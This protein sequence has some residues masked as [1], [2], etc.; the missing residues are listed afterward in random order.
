VIGG[1]RASV[2]GEPLDAAGARRY[3]ELLTG[4]GTPTFALPGPGDLQGG[5]P[6]AFAAAFA[7]AAAPVGTG[8]APDGTTVDPALAPPP[9]PGGSPTRFTFDVSGSAGRVR[10]LAIDNAAGRL[11]GG[12][13][14]PQATWIAR[15]L[16]DARARGVPVVAVGSASL[17]PDSRVAPAA[18]AAYEVA[19]LAGRASAYVAT[20]GG[21]DPAD[22]RFGGETARTVARDPGSGAGLP[23]L[24]TSSLGYGPTYAPIVEENGSLN[25][26]EYA[27]ETT[28]ALLT[29]DVDV[30]RRD[31]ATNVA[32]VA[33]RIELLLGPLLFG[34]EPRVTMGAATTIGANGKDPAQDRRL[35]PAP[36]GGTRLVAGGRVSVLPWSSCVIWLATCASTVPDAVRFS[37]SDESVGRFVG[38]AN[39]EASGGP[40]ILTDDAG[41]PVD[42]PHLGVFCPVGLG[43]TT[44]T[45]RAMGREVRRQITVVPPGTPGAAENRPESAKVPAGTC[46]FTYRLTDPPAESRPDD[47]AAPAEPTTPGA[48]S[49]PSGPA[50]VKSPLL[51]A[52]GSPVTAAPPV[53]APTPAPSAPPAATPPPAVAP[54]VPGPAADPT[55]PPVSPAAKAPSPP[56]P[57]P[58]TG[59]AQVPQT[60][61]APQVQGQ[62]QAQ[63]QG[64]L[65]P[66]VRAAEQDR[67]EHAFEGDHAAA[68]Y[69][70][71]A[72]PLPWEIG[73]AVAVLLLVAG[74][75]VAAGRLR[76]GAAPAYERHRR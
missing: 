36:A 31:P 71:P 5:G 61:S 55:A 74:G 35:A 15:V 1:G 6:Q 49:A 20:A 42:D 39:V 64:Q 33:P 45:L 34:P 10:V 19:L 57:P 50:L 40:V 9:G 75:G 12:P 69:G 16:D 32:P 62:V 3:R 21:D 29:L 37:S 2:G 67:R 18:D 72:S 4:D 73:G 54:V 28:A 14:G 23:V 22:R 59:H 48:P 65:Q 60:G 26:V 66:A 58:P 30:S 47:T 52:P 8:P 27:R 7:S 56:A 53:Q 76:R 38:A 68:A 24:R 43:T 25:E 63:V 11:E 70:R 13:E 51:P 44:V 17:T 46:T 41:R